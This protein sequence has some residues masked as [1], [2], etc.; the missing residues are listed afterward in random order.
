MILKEIF[1]GETFAP[2]T[3]YPQTQQNIPAD[4]FVQTQAYKDYEQYRQLEERLTKQLREKAPIQPADYRALT[5]LNPDY[6]KAY[7][8][9][10]EAYWANG[11]YEEAKEQYKIALT[12]EIPYTI[13]REQIEK[14]LKD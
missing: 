10:G 4:S 3:V 7:Y 6:W 12:K 1:K 5:S 13:E 8:L 11:Q 14:R 2:H 9:L